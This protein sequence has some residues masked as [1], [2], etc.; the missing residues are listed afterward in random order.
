[1]FGVGEDSGDDFFPFSSQ[2]SR[3]S[4]HS[5][6]KDQPSALH[7]TSGNSLNSQTSHASRGRTQSDGRKKSKSR[8]QDRGADDGGGGGVGSPSIRAA[9]PSP[10]AMTSGSPANAFVNQ[11]STSMNLNKTSPAALGRGSNSGLLS[12]R[13]AQG[14]LTGFDDNLSQPSTTWHRQDIVVKKSLL[15]ITR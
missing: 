4:Q 14:S 12:P 1:M 15:E 13:L 9:T 5:S 6:E 11:N 10:R 3:Y 2:M 7:H 8:G